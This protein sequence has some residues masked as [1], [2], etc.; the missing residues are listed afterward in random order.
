VSLL[1]PEPMLIGHTIDTDDRDSN[2]F[3][4]YL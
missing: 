2:P 4:Y 1:V 3:T